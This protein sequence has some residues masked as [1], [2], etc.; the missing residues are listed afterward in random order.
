MNKREPKDDGWD[1]CH[2]GTIFD[3][4]ETSRVGRGLIG[5]VIAAVGL[6]MG[7]IV[8][9]VLA[10]FAPSETP[11]RSLH[12]AVSIDAGVVS[13]A[14]VN[15]ELLAF[16]SGTIPDAEYKKSIAVHILNCPDC[17]QRYKAIC[18]RSEACPSRPQ[19]ATLKPQFVQSP[20]P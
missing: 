20:N 3:T 2:P 7:T 9:V 5:I 13:C 14:S 12:T 18:C 15:A 19:N 10:I 1:P 8:A 11:T 17:R 6:S 4:A 16:V